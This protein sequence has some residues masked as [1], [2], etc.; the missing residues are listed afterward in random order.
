M[1]L[2]STALDKETMNAIKEALSDIGPVVSM[3]AFKF[4]TGEVWLVE[5]K[6]KILAEG[7]Y[8]NES[9]R[10]RGKPSMA[11]E[12]TDVTVVD[13]GIDMPEGIARFVFVFGG[14]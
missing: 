2:Y 8:R 14:A 1:K 4:G 5:A 12:T 7:A 10:I 13:N 3:K 6:G 9:E 11:P